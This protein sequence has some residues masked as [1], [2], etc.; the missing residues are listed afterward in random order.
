MANGIYLFDDV[1]AFLEVIQSMQEDYQSDKVDT[2]TYEDLLQKQ[3]SESN[4]FSKGKVFFI[5]A[6]SETEFMQK[7]AEKNLKTA[8]IVAIGGGGYVLKQYKDDLMALLEKHESER[9]DYLL[10]N[11]YE[12]IKYYLWD[13]EMEISI[14]MTL[15]DLLYDY[16]GL[17]KEQVKENAETINQAIADYKKE[18]YEVN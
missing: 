3:E 4:E 5:F 10:N 2:M 17:T 1:D 6:S 13:F 18:F 9:H 11:M 8:D 15:N 14:S 12:V 16:L 7:L